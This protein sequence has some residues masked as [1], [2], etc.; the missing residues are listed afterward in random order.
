MNSDRNAYVWEPSPSGWKPTL[1][2]LR[3]NRAATFVRWSPSERK[4][5]V[6]SGAQLIA[7][8]YFDEANDW[9]VSKHLKKAVQGTITS[10]AWHPNSL[11]LVA[12]YTD[13]HTRVF[14]GFIKGTDERPQSSVWGERRPFN[15]AGW[16][17]DLHFFQVAMPL[18]S[19]RMIIALLLFIRVAANSHQ[20]AW[21]ASLRNYCR[22]CV[23]SGMEKA[24]SLRLDMYDRQM[25]GG[26]VFAN[27]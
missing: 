13:A 9:W 16:I 8:C 7:I 15:S 24:R 2:L 1:V 25:L 27:I 4:F 21:S 23:L 19:P 11:L 6:G 3:I 5:A 22:S 14:S 17:H 10:V 18:P 26:K 20:E 12:G